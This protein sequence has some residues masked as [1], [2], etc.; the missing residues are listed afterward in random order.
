MKQIQPSQVTVSLISG[1]DGSDRIAINMSEL[2]D[3]VTVLTPAQ[4]RM[5]ATELITAVNRAEVKASLKTTPNLWRRTGNAPARPVEGA[6][7]LG[8]THAR[9][10]TAG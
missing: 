9:L 1:D 6:A 10:A 5:L 4:A 3:S 7:Y 2:M 8:E